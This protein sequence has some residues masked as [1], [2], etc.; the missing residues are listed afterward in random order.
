MK[1]IILLFIWLTLGFSGIAQNSETTL[2]EASQNYNEL[3]NYIDQHPE[4]I[5][6]PGLKKRFARYESFWGHR[7]DH[8][9]NYAAYYR[10]LIKSIQNQDRSENTRQVYTSLGPRH[11]NTPDNIGRVS[12]IWINPD[13]SDHIKIGSAS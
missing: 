13:N 12:S 10:S 11:I 3:I 6:D 5:S 9:G 2:R 4:A 1:R 7:V 8:E